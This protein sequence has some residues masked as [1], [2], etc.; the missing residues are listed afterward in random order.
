MDI[1]L[2]RCRIEK[3]SLHSQFN[4]DGCRLPIPYNQKAFGC[5]K[6]SADRYHET[7]AVIRVETLNLPESTSESSV[8]ILGLSK[9]YVEGRHERV[10]LSRLCAE[11][12][13][14]AIHAVVGRSGSGK[15]TLLNLIAGIDL[16]DRGTVQVAGC[17]INEVNE[18]ERTLFRRRNVGIVFQ[19][20]NLI[21]SLT[22]EENV[23][24]PLELNNIGNRKERVREILS[25]IG[26]QERLKSYP[27]SLS[28][29]EQQRV[30]VARAVI[31]EPKVILADEPTGNLDEQA[32]EQVLHTLLQVKD[33]STVI[34]VTHSRDIA[35]HADCRWQLRAGILEIEGPHS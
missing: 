18:R 5:L 15:S 20:F 22:V 11:F 1:L 31:H 9:S 28:G 34:L 30:A 29:G 16:P 32:A 10:V 19:F 25:K 4:L 23:M 7:I 17:A 8:S 13:A 21:P 26:M 14:G 3:F 2:N 35:N 24:L 27:D 12:H 6:S 33:R